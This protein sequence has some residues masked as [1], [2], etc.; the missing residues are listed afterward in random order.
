M[1]VAHG[2][3]DGVGVQHHPPVH[4]AGRPAHGLDE[5]RGRAQESLLVGVEDGHQ[6]HLGQVEALAEEVDAHQHVEAPEPQVAQELDAGDG[7]HVGVEVPHPDPQ[8]G[9]V[10]GEVLGHLLGEGGD[11]H[12]VAVGRRVASIRSRRSSICPVVGRMTTSGSTSPVGRMTCSTTWRCARAPRA[13]AWPTGGS[14][15]PIRSMNSSNRRG[16]LSRAEGRRNPCSTR[17]SLRDRSP[18]NWPWSWGTATWLSSTTIR[19]SLGKKSSRVK[20][21]SPGA[22]PSRWRL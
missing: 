4:V 10:V 19:K 6:G 7:V 18:S 1:A 3:G 12:P 2:V 9:E 22:R 11:Q 21:A 13:R 14:T 5:R 16:R 8:L 15:W 17:V 20:G